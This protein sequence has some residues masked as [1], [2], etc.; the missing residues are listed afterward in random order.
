MALVW[1]ATGHRDLAACARTIRRRLERAM[2]RAVSDA[3]VR[4]PDGSLFL[5][6]SFGRAVG[7]VRG[8]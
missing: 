1:R 7:A 4:L 6:E 3:L 8:T 5:P 2:R